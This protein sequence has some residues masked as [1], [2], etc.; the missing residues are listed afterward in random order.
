MKLVIELDGGQ[1]ATQV[2]RDANR[3]KFLESKGYRV[4]RFW[5]NDVLQNV[6]GV[7]EV[8]QSAILT[9][10]T[11]N[12][13]PQGGGES[14]ASPPT[15]PHRKRGEGR[16]DAMIYDPSPQRGGEKIDA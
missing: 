1:H 15:P 5:N 12:P 14:T 4:L 16:N 9:T 3:T 8:I 6:D 7:L 11:P 13:S 2:S 10:P